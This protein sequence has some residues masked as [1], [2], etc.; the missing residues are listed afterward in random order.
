MFL[1]A[2][3]LTILPQIKTKKMSISQKKAVTL[4]SFL[5]TP[6]VATTLRGETQ[7]FIILS[8]QKLIKIIYICLK[9]FL[10]HI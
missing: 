6:T 7:R 9:N 4:H 1:K 8:R 10:A 2:Q 3:F 5:P